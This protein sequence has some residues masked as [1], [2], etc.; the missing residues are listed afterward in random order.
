M[1]RPCSLLFV[2]A[3]LS[4]GAAAAV[5]EDR[6]HQ[7]LA[8]VKKD[9]AEVKGLALEAKQEKDIV[10]LGCVSDKMDKIVA[11]LA[12]LRA[13]IV[14]DLKKPRGERTQLERR[15][16]E[17][18]D[19]ARSVAALRAQAGKCVGQ[20]VVTLAEKTA[21]VGEEDDPTYEPVPPVIG[22]RPPPASAY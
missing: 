9:F 1:I 22:V 6:I 17:M 20:K 19:V 11:I 5:T 15:G 12:P 2:L 16:A 7:S 10:R 14:E 8:S 3:A 13:R 21:V 4:L 18:V